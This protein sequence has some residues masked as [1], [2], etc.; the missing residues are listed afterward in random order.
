M[1][2][3][4]VLLLTV[5]MS[6]FSVCNAASIA[7]QIDKDIDFYVNRDNRNYKPKY[8]QEILD[9]HVSQKK[10]VAKDLKDTLSKNVNGLTDIDIRHN[11]FNWTVGEGYCYHLNYFVS[12][13]GKIKESPCCG[14]AS[15]FLKYRGTDVKWF[16][17]WIVDAENNEIVY[18]VNDDIQEILTEQ[19]AYLKE[20]YGKDE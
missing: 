12:F 2:S 20:K 3:L 5:L 15:A 17:I 13:R 1:K 9:W 7:D 14:A 18:S 10:F 11:R 4:I 19:N 6:F 8:V 16:Q